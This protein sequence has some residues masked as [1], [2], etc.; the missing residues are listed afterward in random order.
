MVGF[1]GIVGNVSHNLDAVN[2][3]VVWSDREYDN[4]YQ[5]DNVDLYISTHRSEEATTQ[6]TTSVKGYNL[7]VWGDIIGFEE[8][9]G[10]EPREQSSLSDA[11]YCRSLFEKH[12]ESFVDGLNSEFAG[13][14][15]EPDT[16][17]VTIFTDRL[18]ARPVYYTTAIDQAILFSTHINTIL[19]HPAVEPEY[20]EQFLVEYLTYE[21][22]FGIRTPFKNVS[23][24]HPGSRVTFDAKQ[25]TIS[26]TIYWQPQYNPVERSYK[27]FVRDFSTVYT[28]AIEDRKSSSDNEGVLISGGS[29]SRLAL[30]VLGSD[31]IGFHMN[32]TMNTEAQTAKQV[33]DTIG[34][35]FRLLERDISYQKEVLATVDRFQLYNSF[36]DQAHAAAFDGAIA[37]EVDSIFCGHY[38]DT[39]LSGQYVPQKM[40]QVPILGWNVPTSTPL[41]LKDKDDY[42]DYTLQD[43]KFTRNSNVHTPSYLL[44]NDCIRSIF[45]KELSL[46]GSTVTHHG[47]RYPSLQSLA[48][49]GGYYPLT[50]SN[51]YLFYYTLNQ[52]ASA[53]Y[54]CLDNRVIDFALTMPLKYH[55]E[56]NIVNDSLK[57]LNREL[58]SI[59]HAQTRLPL[60]YPETLHT[61]SE[62]FD[63]FKNKLSIGQAKDEGPWTDHDEVIRRTDIIPE[64]L[65]GQESEELCWE[66]IDIEVVK[67]L[68]ESQLEGESHYFDLYGLLSLCNSYPFNVR[69]LQDVDD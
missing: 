16:S 2:D 15:V 22:V 65:L 6:P 12:G 18:G 52:I 43:H 8:P 1:C 54:P 69:V 11:E 62:L 51:G 64:Y 63:A 9:V 59:P 37:D 44:T 39:V 30:S 48:A 55:T 34:A 3:T 49:T 66:Q 4:R 47:V 35:E 27:E 68:Y 31:S 40:V 38:G 25:E 53:R 50:N 13:A 42:I 14:I 41:P 67:E 46:G 60:T 32:E 7:C 33:C 24:V 57:L 23:K 17:N 5:D 56:N 19:S 29:D 26:K 61:L 28:Q 45:K 58:A 20:D 36:F 10:Y 21:R